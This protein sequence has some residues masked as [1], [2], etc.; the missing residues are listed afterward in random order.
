VNNKQERI[1]IQLN[2]TGIHRELPGI[3]SDRIERRSPPLIALLR[4]QAL[5][6][7]AEPTIDEGGKVD[8]GKGNGPALPRTHQ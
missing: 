8:K 4:I 5:P 7:G 2:A 3:E 6:V 1:S